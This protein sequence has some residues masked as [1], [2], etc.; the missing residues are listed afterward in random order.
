MSLA[1]N[2]RPRP[3]FDGLVELLRLAW[4]VV[5]NRVGIMVMG[6]TDAIVVGHY[7]ARELGYHGL[8]WAPHSIVVTTGVGLLLGVQVMV[9]RAVG[10][11]RPGHAG[12]ALRRGFVYA[13]LLGLASSAVLVLAGPAFLGLPAMGLELD[14]IQG[15][16]PALQVFALSLPFYLVA[17]ALTFFLEA[18]GRPKAGMTAMWLANGVNLALNLW[19]VPGGSGLPVEG[20]VGSAWATFGARL[21]LCVLLVA[22]VARLP[23]ARAMGLFRKPEPDRKA[24]AEQLR[25]GYGAGASYFI[26]VG[27]FAG[28]TFVAGRLGVLEVAAWNVV[29]NVAAIIFMAPLGLA[30]ATAVLVGRAYGA[31]DP[32]GV[33]RAGHLGFGVAAAA[34]ALIC[35]VVWPG[36]GL[37]ARAY[38]S[39]PL[40]LAVAVPA[41]VLSCL[42]FVADGVQVVAAQALRARG[43]VWVPTGMHLVSYAIVMLPLA[44]LFAEP[45]GLGVNGIVWAVIVASLV[46]A[47]LLLARWWTLSRRP[48]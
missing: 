27:A 19:L 43:D 28:A 23:E 39:D 34:T 40:L 26:E 13:V 36:A 20:A 21:A 37:I 31:N 45:W 48:L 5:L 42:F 33:R 10:E 16:G 44:W 2:T 41:L 3:A 17:V 15:A 25:I 32:A 9:A 46:S 29:L 6:L 12:A 47:G 30:S 1:A 8:G 11:G 24:A 14:L 7:S 22:W 4:P 18:L 35:V 38:S